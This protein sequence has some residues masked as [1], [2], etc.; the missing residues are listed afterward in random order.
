MMHNSQELRYMDSAPL[1]RRILALA[2]YT[3]DEYEEDVLIRKGVVTHEWVIIY[4][5]FGSWTT[6]PYTGSFPVNVEYL[7]WMPLPD[8]ENFIKAAR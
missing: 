1:D 8:M 5:I 2:R 4:N 7:G 6:F 3:R